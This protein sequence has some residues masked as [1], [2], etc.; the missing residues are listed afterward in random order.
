M[1]LGGGGGGARD[2]CRDEVNMLLNQPRTFPLLCEEAAEGT[3]VLR[4]CGAGSLCRAVPVPTGTE[5]VLS[6]DSATTGVRAANAKA[7]QFAVYEKK[8]PMTA[9]STG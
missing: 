5:E 7:F 8:C 1:V 4:V 3:A 9:E 6:A 2:G